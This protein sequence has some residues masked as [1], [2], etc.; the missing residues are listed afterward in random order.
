MR[1]FAA[2]CC[3]AAVVSTFPADAAQS[4]GVRVEYHEREFYWDKKTF[5]SPPELVGGPAALAKYLDY[6]S[7]LRAGRIQARSLV[8]VLV[9]ANGRVRQV[10]LSPQLDQE[11]ERIVLLAVN[12]S[13][14]RP[15]RKNGSTKDGEI[16]FFIT[17][18][19]SR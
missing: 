11:L 9:G 17:F 10:S 12:R 1:R 15:G 13:Q 18:V 14:W 8:T 19:I 3:L 16:S 5:D 6:P 4:P 2:S 7:R